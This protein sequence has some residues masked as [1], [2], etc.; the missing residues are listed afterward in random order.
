[1]NNSID[2]VNVTTCISKAGDCHDDSSVNDGGN[3][4]DNKDN[5]GADELDT[6][7]FLPSRITYE[8]I[9][10]IGSG[11]MGEVHKAK[12]HTSLGISEIVVLKMLKPNIVKRL[13][14][15]DTTNFIVEHFETETRIL[16]ELNG[17]PNIVGFKGADYIQANKNKRMFFVMEY[18]DGFNLDDLRTLHRLTP[19]GILNREAFSIQNE[20]IGF[21]LFK[22]ANALDYAHNYDTSD[23]K[24]GIV[25]LDIAPGNIL[26]NK[27]LGL[28]KL[29]DFGIA[30]TINDISK[31]NNMIAGNLSYISPERVIGETTSNKSD[32]YSLGIVMYELLTGINPNDTKKLSSTDFNEKKDFLYNMYVQKLIPPHE[33]AKGVNPVLSNIV[34]TLME[35]NPD[36]RYQSSLKLREDVGHCIYDSGFGPTESSFAHYLAKIQLLNY[37]FGDHKRTNDKIVHDYVNIVNKQRDCLQ[38]YP[39]A[40]KILEQGGNPCRRAE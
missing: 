16:S 23:G 3:I 32:L 22:V 30:S 40:L 12:L 6:G 26:I 20:F 28:I 34:M 10:Q 7:K 13:T 27:K 2:S 11:G 29:A 4:T 1:M 21:I 39:D 36:H 24:H 17:H 37:H 35:L 18:I 5:V 15:D 31:Q 8:L 33:I 14:D 38:L 25:H 9:E 19:A